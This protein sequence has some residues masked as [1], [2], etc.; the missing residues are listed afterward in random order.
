MTQENLGGKKVAVFGCGDSDAFPDSFCRAVDII[1]QKARACGPEIIAGPFKI[2]GDVDVYHAD[3]A[4]WAW[5]LV[6]A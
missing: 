5:N 3:I 2:D 1:A 6:K 4:S